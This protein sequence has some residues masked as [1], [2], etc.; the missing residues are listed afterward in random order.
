MRGEKKIDKFEIDAMDAPKYNIKTNHIPSI[1][2][3][4][5]TSEEDSKWLINLYDGKII[6]NRE[7]FP[8]MAPDE[9]VAEFC[10]I[11]EKNFSVKFTKRGEN[12]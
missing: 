2:F 7:D 8:D 4:A 5:T 3:Y 10:R 6:L 1:K 9:F 11:L 12:S